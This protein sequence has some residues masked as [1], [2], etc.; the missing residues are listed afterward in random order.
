LPLEL[1]KARRQELINLGEL[2]AQV[3]RPLKR[4]HGLFMLAGFQQ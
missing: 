2:R 4:L 1:E 3:Q